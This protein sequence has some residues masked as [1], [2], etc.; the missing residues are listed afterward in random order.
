M[1]LPEYLRWLEREIKI[2]SYWMKWIVNELRII[3]YYI[4]NLRCS[5]L[6]LTLPGLFIDDI[7]HH[8]YY[9]FFCN[10]K[11][12]LFRSHGREEKF[13]KEKKN[14]IRMNEN[15]I[16][17]RMCNE[18]AKGIINIKRKEIFSKRKIYLEKK[19]KSLIRGF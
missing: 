5:F 12:S 1:H 3:V 8:H 6:T 13:Q 18:Q 15:W 11:S 10:C 7:H 4:V 2:F 9:L 17:P 19:G 16:E 14:H